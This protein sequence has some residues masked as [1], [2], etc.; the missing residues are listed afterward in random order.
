MRLREQASIQPFSLPPGFLLTTINL[1]SVSAVAHAALFSIRKNDRTKFRRR[2]KIAFFLSLV[3][4]VVQSHGLV[5]MIQSQLQPTSA[6]RNLYGLT[7]VL[8]ILHALHVIGGVAGLAMLIRRDTQN[9][10]NAHRNFPVKFCV[11]YWHF[12]DL[13]WLA[14]LACFAVAIFISRKPIN[15]GDLPPW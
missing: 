5:Q 2:L 11:L 8:V 6:L 15:V 3:F 1:L 12:L 4:F 7:F 14:M 10:Y 13:V 9:A